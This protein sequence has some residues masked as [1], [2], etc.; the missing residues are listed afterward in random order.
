V[1]DVE[2]T[3]RPYLRDTQT[4][5]Y[6]NTMVAS[7]GAL[8]ADGRV[9][10]RSTTAGQSATVFVTGAVD[11]HTGVDVCDVTFNGTDTHLGAQAVVRS[12]VKGEHQPRYVG[13]LVG[14]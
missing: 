7:A 6:G 14:A 9:L 4:D 3:S 10:L 13:M 11:Q 1:L 12:N 5:A 2:P 8:A